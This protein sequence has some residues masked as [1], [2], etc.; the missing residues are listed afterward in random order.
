M[1]K[2][3]T[4][5]PELT[6]EER[7]RDFAMFYA[8]V[9]FASKIVAFSFLLFTVVSFFVFEGM[10]LFLFASLG[11][12]CFFFSRTL[13]LYALKYI[14]RNDAR[15][16]NALE[17]DSPHYRF[18]KNGAESLEESITIA[19]TKAV[20]RSSYWILVFFG[21]AFSVSILYIAVGLAVLF[22][23]FKYL[24]NEDKQND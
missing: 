4:E 19:K 2:K 22:M 3:K 12:T 11:S 8:T 9:P 23:L 7:K 1:S 5:E 24:N 14:G 15:D 20:S 16:S 21:V 18:W 13:V 10:A 17:E 6:P